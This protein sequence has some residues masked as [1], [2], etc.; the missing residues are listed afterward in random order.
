MARQR[1]NVPTKPDDARAER[2]IDALRSA[3]L[4]L[5]Q[6]KS[7]HQ[8]SIKNI[9]DAAGVSYPTFFRRFSSKEALLEDIA[10]A[11]VRTLLSLS[12]TAIDK[13]NSQESGETLCRYVQEH[14]KL[15]T[16]LLTGGAALT[17]RQEF[18]RIA[19]EIGYERPR[20]N[21]WLPVDLAVPFVTSGIFEIIAWW[22]R[23]P[24]DYPL[25]NVIKLFDA[26][27]IDTA[28]RRRNITLE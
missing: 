27:I 7:F 22:M 16:A 15:W 17:M 25:A 12:E 23:Q 24:E 26:L 9:T 11:E 6:N 21:P 14:R 2:S 3:L 28:R 10:T 1:I 4:E 13:R 20:N 18:M 19:Q 5:I 8:I